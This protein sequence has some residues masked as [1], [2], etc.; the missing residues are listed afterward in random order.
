MKIS[1]KNLSAFQPVKMTISIESE[2]EWNAWQLLC[3]HASLGDAIMQL[4]SE[5]M[6]LPCSSTEG[7]EVYHSACKHGPVGYNS[8]VEEINTL[9]E[10][11]W[12][13]LN[14]VGENET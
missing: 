3:G 8:A 12:Q 14:V 11:M 4:W 1:R 9:G 10:F 7:K 13:A 5:Q 2:A 6:D